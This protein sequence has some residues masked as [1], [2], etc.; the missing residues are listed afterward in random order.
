M[1]F[2]KYMFI[3]LSMLLL[4]TACNAE[5]TPEPQMPTST[6]SV[7]PISTPL[8]TETNSVTES[9]SIS[10]LDLIAVKFI[11]PERV[12][13]ADLDP[14]T[15]AQ[16]VVSQYLQTTGD[17][18]NLWAGGSIMDS[19]HFF[20]EVE[21][22]SHDSPNLISVTFPLHLSIT[23]EADSLT[24]LNI[25]S[26]MGGGGGGIAKNFPSLPLQAGEF[27]LIPDDPTSVI[28][29]KAV[30][31]LSYNFT[32]SCLQSGV[33][34]LQ[35]EIPYSV[36][37]NMTEA[38]HTFEYGIQVVCPESATLWLLS[39]P[40]SGQIENGGRWFFQDGRYVLQN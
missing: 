4:V 8:P 6:I 7:E 16:A 38:E 23:E 24:D 19:N 34:D 37:G 10:E 28:L 32:M 35:F 31:Q 14:V 5:T 13:P 1:S 36:T 15:Q 27:E 12:V 20:L 25:L 17:G 39:D 30:E 26:P 40:D 2:F 33:F 29:M 9:V 18:S 21:A 22:L 11:D 3:P